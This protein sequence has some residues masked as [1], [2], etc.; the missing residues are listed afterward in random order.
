MIYNE[1]IKW[2]KHET[3]RVPTIHKQIQYY[4]KPQGAVFSSITGYF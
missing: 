4:R 1:G 3:S 2:D